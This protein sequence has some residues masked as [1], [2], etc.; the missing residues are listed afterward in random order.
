MRKK[1]KPYR[2]LTS[3]LA[4]IIGAFALSMLGMSPLV[5]VMG[6]GCYQLIQ[7]SR[8]TSRNGVCY[9]TALSEEQIKEFENILNEFKALGE[10]IPGIKALGAVEG[11]FAALKALPG[12]F[13]SEQA[14]ADELHAQVKKLSRQLFENTPTGVRWVNGQAH[15]TEDCAKYIGGMA[16]IRAANSNKLK[17]A[18]AE[19]MIA[20]AAGF[21]GMEAKAAIAATDIPLPVQYAAQIVELVYAY[22]QARKLCTVY[23]LGMSSVKLPRLKTGEPAFGFIA[24]SGAVPEKVPQMEFVTFT[25]GKCGGIVRIPSE[26]EADSIIA[27]GQFVAR[28]IAR[29]MSKIE[30]MCVFIGDGSATYNNINGIGAQAT[31]DGGNALLTL[32]ATKTKPSDIQLGD[33]R[34]L[35]STVTGAVLQRAAYY[36]HPTMD[37]LFV[38]YNTSATVVPYQR[39]PDGSA[40]LDGFP[41]IWVNTMPVYQTVANP[42][43][44]QV[45]FGDLSWWYFGE[46]MTM[47]VETSREV[48]FATDETP[49]RF[50]RSRSDRS[51]NSATGAPQMR[52]AGCCRSFTAVNGS[53][54]SSY[55]PLHSAR[56]RRS[57]KHSSVVLTAMLILR[58]TLACSQRVPQ[59]QSLFLTPHFPKHK[60]IIWKTLL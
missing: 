2:S 15:V 29:E 46:R 51:V 24:V 49:T 35:R 33:V 1:L 53:A 57:N 32:A 54:R 7:I 10:F 44:Y 23:P 52:W 21:L 20:R 37:A 6:V 47:S 26:I 38:Q 30:D 9:L 8:K 31:A 55:K 19:D 13:K 14:R 4:V 16:V 11:G 5:C 40:T 39:K 59:N 48:Y 34:D 58:L 25:P 3:L 12:L 18:N 17:G 36:A 60:K 50:P 27:V 45:Y 56:R 41:V 42:G 22:G 43:A 28:Y